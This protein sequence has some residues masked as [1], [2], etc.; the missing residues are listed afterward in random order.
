MKPVIFDE[1]NSNW[2]IDLERNIL[3]LRAQQAYFNHALRARGHVFLN[4]VY[5]AL[6]L[7]RTVDGSISG[8]SLSENPDTFVDFGLG[9]IGEAGKRMTTFSLVFNI[10]GVIFHTIEK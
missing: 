3:F 1:Y 10:D 9:G 5:D 2:S 7:P 6:G 8:W 4:E